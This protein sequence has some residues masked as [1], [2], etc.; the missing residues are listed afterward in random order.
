MTEENKETKTEPT[1]IISSTALLGH[2][3]MD[4]LIFQ[5]MRSNSEKPKRTIMRIIKESVPVQQHNQ[6]GESLMRLM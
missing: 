3:E 6:I 4:A 2:D 1:A 5:I